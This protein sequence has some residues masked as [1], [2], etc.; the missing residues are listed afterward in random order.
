MAT[1]DRRYTYRLDVMDDRVRVSAPNLVP[2]TVADLS[3]SGSGLLVSTDDMP[4]VPAEQAK[5]DLGARRSFSVKLEPVR[6]SHADGQL[7]IGARF[8][9][10]QLSGMRVLSEFLIREFLQEKSRLDRLLEDPRTLTSDS[11]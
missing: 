7:R 8:E 5:Y 1:S 10:L 3:A 11:P 4:G 9:N 2:M 6:V